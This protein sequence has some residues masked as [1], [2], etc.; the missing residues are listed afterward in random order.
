MIQGSAFVSHFKADTDLLGL[1]QENLLIGYHNKSGRIIVI[2]IDLLF[3]NL[4]SID[5]RCVFT[6]DC[7]LCRI[8]FIQDFLCCYCCIG[9]TDLLPASMTVQEFGALHQCLRM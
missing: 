7:R 1:L 8:I 2:V 9:R 6:A 5:L 4:K 3:Q